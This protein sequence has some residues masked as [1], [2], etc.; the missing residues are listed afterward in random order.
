MKRYRE[1]NQDLLDLDVKEELFHGDHQIYTKTKDNHPTNYGPDVSVNH[2]IVGSGCKIDGKINNSVLFRD[3][4]IGK[5]SHID[6]CIIMQHAVIG[7]N[8]TLKNVI[9]DKY[10]TIRD[11]ATLV[12]TKDD[13][14]ILTK[15]RSL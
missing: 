4:K 5:D 10:C 14:I 3:S 6:D 15:G 13:P 11:K 1:I 8:V 9:L 2:S 12:G 7:D